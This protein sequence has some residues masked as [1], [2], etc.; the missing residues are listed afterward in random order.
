MRQIV[1][2]ATSPLRLSVSWAFA[3]SITSVRKVVRGGRWQVTGQTEH[4]LP[5]ALAEGEAASAAAAARSAAAAEQLMLGSSGRDVSR[6]PYRT[7][8][9]FEL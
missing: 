4:G 9:L 7:E 3:G 8:H 5:V 2:R 6:H 1:A